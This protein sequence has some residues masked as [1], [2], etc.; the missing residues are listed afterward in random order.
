MMENRKP[1]ICL[2]APT[3]ELL[4]KSEFVIMKYHKNIETHKASLATAAEIVNQ[5]LKKGTEIF[6]SRRG[7]KRLIEKEFH[8]QVV[9][10]ELTLADYI[11]VIEEAVKVEGIVA[12]FT[13]GKIPEDV[14]TMCQI[15]K[16]DAR[17]SSFANFTDCKHVVE[18]ALRDGAVLGIGGADTEYFAQKEGLRHLVVENSE[19]SLLRAINTSEQLLDMK[20]KEQEKQRELKVKL[21]RYELVLNYTHDAI[22]AVDREGQI[23][24]LNEGAERI[25][26]GKRGECLGRQV[27]EVLPNTRLKE[28]MKK[29]KRE[30][31]Q[32][33]TINGTLVSTNRIPIIVDGEVMGAVAT[34]QDVKALQDSEQKIRIKL[35]QKGLFAKYNFEDIIG[36]SYK[37]RENISLAKKFARSDATILI[38][39]ETGTGKELF[40]QSIHNASL[41]AEGPF[42]AV[43]CGSLPRNLLEAELFGYVEGAFTG[44]SKGGKMGLFEMAH[45]GTIFLDEI[46]EMPV[47]TQVQLLRVLQEKEIRRIGSDRVTPVNIRVITATNRDLYKEIQEKGFREDLYYRLN[48]L[49]IVIPPL[50]E[51][52]ADIIPIGLKLFDGYADTGQA[53]DILFVKQLLKKL[54]DYDWPGNV[55]E[56]GNMMERAY[57][58]LSQKEE[59][60]FVDKYIQSY[61]KI[62]PTEK[63]T[64]AGDVKAGQMSDESGNL[65]NWEMENIY[66]TGI[67]EESSR[68]YK[69]G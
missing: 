19:E 45:G 66:C 27:D 35:H 60:E 2:I 59:Y 68:D 12:F 44:A 22:I 16:I 69:D 30:L 50:R 61:L 43:N 17:Y 47:E 15:L 52:R 32:L 28:V 64:D 53:E 56:L 1:E 18:E 55:R 39:G 8:V 38:Q 10:I 3:D 42:V 14:R 9:E 57:V 51:R 24:V 41:R 34:F 49:N 26:K 33:M 46:G 31:N 6:I 62:S 4:K 29:G 63:R 48:V 65:E 21:E 67:K 54:R 36:N 5:L 40:A 20:R 13:Y 58:L 25:M 37:L 11:S 23:D 7:T